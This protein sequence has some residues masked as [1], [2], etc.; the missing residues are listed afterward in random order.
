MRSQKAEPSGLK[1]QQILRAACEVFLAQ[2]YEGASVDDIV[3]RAGVSKPTLYARFPEKRALF[4]AVVRHVCGEEANRVFELP[5][6]THGLRAALIAVGINYLSLVLSPLAQRMYRMV[7]SEVERIPEV[8]KVFY[9]SGPLLGSQRI[10]ALLEAAI[11]RGELAAGD[12]LFAAQQF[13]ELC[14]TDLLYKVYFG[15]QERATSEEIEKAATAATDTFLA[16][17]GQQP[18][19]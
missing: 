6:A 16:A 4:V 5:P 2:G 19:N 7:I 15:L 18:K 14:R 3:R 8:G 10:A 1:T 17:Y 13:I 12:P 9:E 11:T